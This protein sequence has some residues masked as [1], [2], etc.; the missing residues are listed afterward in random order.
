MILDTTS[1]PLREA[2]T[3]NY[4]IVASILTTSDY[5]PVPATILDCKGHKQGA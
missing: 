5:I 1:A 2:H 3:L 4:L